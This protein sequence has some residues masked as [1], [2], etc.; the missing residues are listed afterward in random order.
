MAISDINLQVKTEQGTGFS[1]KES[2][3]SD[4]ASGLS[5]LTSL[6]QASEAANAQ[7]KSDAGADSVDET[8][9]ISL[10]EEPKSDAKLGDENTTSDAKVATATTSTEQQSKT[11]PDIHNEAVIKEQ[12]DELALV[13]DEGNSLLSQINAAQAM[14]TKVNKLIENI[15]VDFI[16]MCFLPKYLLLLLG[17]VDL[18]YA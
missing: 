2:E 14:S 1:G 8:K 15:L 9:A 13:E 16:A 5:F 12:G 4:K 10:S 17:S 3:S 6:T 18:C 7:A 11:S